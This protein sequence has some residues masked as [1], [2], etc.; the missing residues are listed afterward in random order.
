ME[1]VIIIILI[2]INGIFSLAEM[3]LVSSRRF[4]LETASKK[5][6]SGAKTAIE[7]SEN[8]TK[9]L[10]TVQIGI[11][12]IGI[13][14]GVFSGENLTHTVAEFLGQFSLLNPYAHQIAVGIIVILVT[15][16]SIV[17]GELLPKRIGMT[18]PE[19]IA[20][21]LAKPMKFV[22]LLTSP[23]VWL[24]MSTNDLFLKILGIRKSNDSNVSEEEIKSLIKE[25]TEGGE[26]QD[27]EHQIVER[28]FE[29]GD[30]KVDTL[31]THRNELVYFNEDES[32]QSITAKINKEKHSAY[33]VCKNDDIDEIIGIALLKDL[34]MAK[35]DQHFSIKNFIKPAIFINESSYA[36]KVL[37]I[38]KKERMHYGIVVDEYGSTAGMVTMD[39]VVDALVGDVTEN[40]QSEYEIVK[41]NENSWLVDGQYS[42]LEFAKF[43]E[44]DIDDNV[45]DSYNTVAGL[46]IS[47]KDQLPNV[48]DTI[49]ID[50]L[51]IEVLDKDGQRIDKLL[52]TK[53]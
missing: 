27:I 24:L 2:L 53:M 29:L 15:Y 4:K 51:Q 12:L 49:T 39:D 10:S 47:Q 5:G 19:P 17:F 22:S 3:S 1:L 50:Q 8:P 52:V 25:G 37:E 9:F 26:I 43:F 34:F 36:Y 44:L 16:L 31:F 18:F 23:F 13:L 11:T 38:F 32:L 46:I 42:L 41:R 20:M 40:Y 35:D 30:R 14:L 21:V 28:V 33:P 45:I 7:L 6:M 48:G